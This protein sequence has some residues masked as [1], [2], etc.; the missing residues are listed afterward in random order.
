MAIELRGRHHRREQDDLFVDL[1]YILGAL[2]QGSGS[3]Y[4]KERSYE[5]T[6][7]HNEFRCHGR[8]GHYNV[9]HDAMSRAL[10]RG[11]RS[12]FSE[13]IEHTEML[14]WFTH[15]LFI[16]YD[17]KTDLVEHVSHYIQM[18]SL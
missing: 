7:R 1:D 12:P 4:S 10:R 6:E 18:I 8:H 3:R 13:Q 16:I 2:S 15:P 5:T 9:A 17:G 11:A 14:R